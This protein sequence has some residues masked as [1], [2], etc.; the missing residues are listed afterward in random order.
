MR[1]LRALGGPDLGQLDRARERMFN[2]VH[3]N[4]D[5]FPLVDGLGPAAPGQR[6]LVGTDV[7]LI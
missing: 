4:R 6:F 7:L 1:V 5:V 2:Q 3:G